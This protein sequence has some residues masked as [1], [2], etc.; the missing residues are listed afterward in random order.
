MQADA[1]VDQDSLGRWLTVAKLLAASYGSTSVQKEH[2]N[3]MLAMEA[4]RMARVAA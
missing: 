1:T 4:Q 2:W 3:Q